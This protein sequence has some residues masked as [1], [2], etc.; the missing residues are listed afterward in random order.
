MRLALFDQEDHAGKLQASAGISIFMYLVGGAFILDDLNCVF[1]WGWCSTCV[2]LLYHND[3][4]YRSSRLLIQELGWVPSSLA[5][6]ES[7]TMLTS[8][9]T[10][11][12]NSGNSIERNSIGLPK[13]LRG[14]VIMNMGGGPSCCT[15]RFPSR[16]TDSSLYTS[17]P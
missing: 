2:R 9:V 16:S 6:V 3:R 7:T 1:V 15:R 13:N 8:S 4:P 10:N 14:L 12:E 11:A 17:S 5:A